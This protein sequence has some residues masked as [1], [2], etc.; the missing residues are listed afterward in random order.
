MRC[1]FIGSCPKDLD[2]PESNEDKAAVSEDGLNVA[3]CDGASESYNSRLWAKLLAEKYVANSAVGPEWVRQAVASYVL[4]HDFASMSW[5][6]QA[7]F[8]RG[9]FATLL[10][11]KSHPDQSLVEVLAI[12]DCIAFLTDGDRLVDSWPFDDPEQFKQRPTLLS[13][14]SELNAFVDDEGFPASCART[15]DIAGLAQ[16]RIFC[17]SDAIGEWALRVASEDKGISKWNELLD[18]GRLAEV[19]VEQRAAKRMRIDDSTVIVLSFGN[20]DG[21]PVS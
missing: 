13:T 2:D 16:P 8:E 21:I 6:K 14:Q 7:A 3:L 5:S 10:G 11:V 20:P 17:M 12:G 18:P 4:E 9:S 1:E 19:V 15:F